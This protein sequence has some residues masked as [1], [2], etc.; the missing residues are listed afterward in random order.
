MSQHR[1]SLIVV[2]PGGKY[3]SCIEYVFTLFARVHG[4]DCRFVAKAELA[5]SGH[6][7][8]VVSY[9]D[10][11]AAADVVLGPVG[12]GSHLSIIASEFFKEGASNGFG[13]AVVPSGF[14]DL[15]AT[16]K[17]RAFSSHIDRQG[18]REAVL[19]HDI[20]SASFYLLTGYFEWATPQRDEFG[21]MLSS[22]VPVSAETWDLPMVNHW[23]RQLDEL[24]HALVS[25]ESADQPKV[26]APP[27]IQ[28]ICLTHD[29]DLLR[30]YRPGRAAKSLLKSVTNPAS[31]GRA[32][33]DFQR[34][35]SSNA[36]DPYDSFDALYMVKERVSAPSTFF[37]LGCGPG[38]HNGDYKPDDRD[39]REMFTRAR[40]S[41]D[42]IAL[43]GS[44]DSIDDCKRLAA[45]KA[46]VEKA[47][48]VKINGGRQHYLR[49]ANPESWNTADGAGLKYDST[50]GFPDRAGFKYG[51]SGCFHPFDLDTL[52]PLPIIE[53][54]L[55]CMDVTLANYE[56]IPAELSLE[57]LTNLLDASCEDVPG[58][59]FVFLWHNIMADREQFPG[60]WD[61][62]EYF[63][64]VASGSARFVTLGQLCEEFGAG[65]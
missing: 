12:H 40:T 63:F 28:T 61:T 57:R 35:L 36:S 56:K 11:S 2:H 38:G 21:R 62:F 44:W 51:W 5:V 60:Y 54:P 37:F 45:E 41:G 49:F 16:V 6:A 32:M 50:G 22:Q 43:H 39:V 4:Y 55:V 3:G 42:E 58:G 14:T 52:K 23:F 47:A 15:V 59:A 29:V 26:A 13:S 48:R 30:K 9:R 18:P 7:D 53:I 64:S 33:G 24:L 17:G 34:A 19:P 46:A 65:D 20:V 25:G 1:Y 10:E 27:G 8:V 31:I